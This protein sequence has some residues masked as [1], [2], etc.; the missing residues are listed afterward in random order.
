[1]VLSAALEDGYLFLS[2][3]A[4]LSN[5]TIAVCYLAVLKEVFFEQSGYKV[6][7]SRY[8][9][10]IFQNRLKTTKACLC[11]WLHPALHQLQ[12]FSIRD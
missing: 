9:D 2:L 6:F 7:H 11:D 3:V 4:V 5:V 12:M 10:I 8:V 1:M